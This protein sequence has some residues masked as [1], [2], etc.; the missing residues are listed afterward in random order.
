[1]GGS[2]R[3]CASVLGRVQGVGFRAFVA[4]E[5]DRLGLAGFCRNSPAGDCVQVEAE[6]C[7]AGLERLLAALRQG[8]PLAHVR[9][10]EV[11]WQEA[12]GEFD[13]F[14]IHP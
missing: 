8:P 10:V 13:R 6:G 7:R 2:S 9:H 1:V 3:L 14:R 12:T 11:E 4:L 5:A